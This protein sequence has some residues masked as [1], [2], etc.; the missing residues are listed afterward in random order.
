MRPSFIRFLLLLL[1][2]AAVPATTR[3]AGGQTP[4]ERAAAPAQPPVPMTAQSY[5]PAT[6]A[7]RVEWTVVGTVGPQSLFVVG[8]LS[9]GFHTWLNEPSEWQQTWSGFGK[10]YLHR[11][12]DVAI[13]NTMEAGL[14]AI[15]GEEPRYVPSGRRGIGARARYAIKTAF[16]TQ[17]RDGHLAPAWGRYVANT[18]NNVIENSWLPPSATT[19]GQTALRSA[20]GF[21]SRIGGNAWAEFWP[22]AKQRFF[23][24]KPKP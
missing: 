23:T 16:V 2:A 1:L 9:A 6:T 20:M 8:P 14:G 22:D 17:R 10:R 15:W 13:S 12:A 24:R 5:V 19:P 21:A 4:A 3:A 18:L 11:E 7:D